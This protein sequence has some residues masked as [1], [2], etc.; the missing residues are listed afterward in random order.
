[1]GDWAVGGDAVQHGGSCRTAMG[2][3][4]ERGGSDLRKDVRTREGEERKPR[5]RGV[6][7]GSG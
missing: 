6:E 4:D 1:M 5:E 3:D 7:F 2:G